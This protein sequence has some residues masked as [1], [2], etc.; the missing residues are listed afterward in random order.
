MA[1][2][3]RQRFRDAREWFFDEYLDAAR[4]K[5]DIASWTVEAAVARGVLP[6]APDHRE[7]RDAP[8]EDG[9]TQARQARFRRLI[10]TEN[11]ATFRDCLELLCPAAEAA[12]FLHRF[13]DPTFLVSQAMVQALAQNEQLPRHRL[14]DIC[15]GTGHLA[16]L[17]CRL[18]GAGTVLLADLD[19]GKT[20]LAKKFVASDCEA[21]C[22]DASQ[23]LPFARGTFSLVLCSDGMNYIWPRRLF[24]GELV[25]L[26]ES[27]GVIL[28]THLHNS[29]RDNPSPGMPL[30][31][32]GYRRLFESLPH[33][34]FKESAVL[35]S[36][37]RQRP[38]RL[39][40]ILS[41]A[42]LEAEP[43]MVLVGTTLSGL[44]REYPLPR[45]EAAA[46]RLS[47]NPL[48]QVEHTACSDILRRRF[49]SAYYEQ[50]FADC[51]R[52][53][54]ERFE[55]NT[56]QR[57]ALD[58]GESHPELQELLD[59]RVLLDLPADYL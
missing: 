22:C 34:L 58:Q 19:F 24:A 54:V 1:T 18:P 29:L 41:D 39:D 7:A 16:R 14:L 59:R 23:A 38:V 25:R 52:Y 51:K 10:E 53:L 3:G 12:Y 9:A 49:P 48:Y 40:Q 37:L 46:G 33:R 55:L 32:D 27:D 36:I 28:L 17:L 21:I 6:P 4:V 20:W 43:A 44:F 5:T 42:E 13:S 47:I 8:R 45:P 50:E 35:D 2:V 57:A 26:L 56:Q 30:R 15:G 31:P 11:H